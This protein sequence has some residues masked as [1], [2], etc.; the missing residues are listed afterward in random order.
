MKGIQYYKIREKFDPR[1]VGKE[2]SKWHD[3]KF[4]TGG[5]HIMG[6]R[7]ALVFKEHLQKMTHF[8]KYKVVKVK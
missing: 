4:Q 2:E 6:Y 8:V 5:H 3:E 1:V 7:N